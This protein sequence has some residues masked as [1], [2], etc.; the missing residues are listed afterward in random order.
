MTAWR[1]DLRAQIAQVLATS[2]GT[3][4]VD[5]IVDA[6]WSRG[7]TDTDD[8]EDFWQ[9]VAAHEIPA[10]PDP[11]ERMRAELSATIARTRTDRASLWRDGLVTVRVRGVSPVNQDLP[12]PLASATVTTRLGERRLAGDELTWPALWDAVVELREA[13]ED[14]ARTAL[15]EAAS[16]HRAADLAEQK[17]A[18]HRARRDEAVCAADAAGVAVSAIAARLGLSEAAVRKILPR[19]AAT[20]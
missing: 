2:E 7:V 11:A 13:A 19:K 17:A 16:Q 14:A 6:L 1:E 4:D 18:R 12:Q 10:A 15:D 20:L 8:A 3:Y 5:A 9:V